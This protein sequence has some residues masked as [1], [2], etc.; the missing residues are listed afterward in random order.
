MKVKCHEVDKELYVLTINE[1]RLDLTILDG[2]VSID[3]YNVLHADRDRNGGGV[4]IYTRCH[5]NYT[6]LSDLVPTDLEAVC[7][8]INQANSQ[9]FIISSIYTPPCSTNEV[10]KKN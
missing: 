6:P 8:E 9:P 10:F 7:V 3:G 4:C 5:V 1:T 2:L